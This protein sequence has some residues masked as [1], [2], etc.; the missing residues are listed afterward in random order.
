M[1]SIST[2]ATMRT[3]DQLYIDGSWTST[4]GGSIDVV[5]PSTESVCGRIPEATPAD[6]ELAVRAAATALP[7]WSSTPPEERRKA[8]LAL[9]EGLSARQA[10]LGELISTEQGMPLKLATIIQAGLPAA[11]MAV[12]ADLLDGVV[13]E[14]RIGN[15]LVVKEPVGVVAAITPWNYPLHQI[16]AKVAPALVAGC[17]VV[18]KPSEVAPLNAFVLAE[19][20]DDVGL[21]AGVFNLVSGTGP[22]VGEALVGHELVDMVSFT[23]STRAGRRVGEV[24]A[25]R[26]KKVALELG[27]KS[28]NVLLDDA[29]LDRVVEPG[30]VNACFLNSGQTCTALTRMLVPRHLQSQVVD[31]ARKAAE[32]IVVGPSDAL[33]TRLGPVVSAAQRDRVRSF[34]Q[35]GID[36]GATLV[37]GGVDAPDGLDVGYFIRPTVFADV[38]PDMRIAQEEIFGPVLSIMPYDSDE[39]A[40][41][42]A[43]GTDYGLSG[44]VQSADQDRAVAFARRMRTGQVDVNG[45]PYNLQA[46]F[47]G[48]KQ[49]GIGRENG[50]YGI[51]E[52]LV[53]KGLT[54]PA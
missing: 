1:C 46:P 25:A 14:E 9:A 6:V 27:G 37:T 47:G 15:T 22:L 12:H 26:V 42:I 39:E 34:I 11:N 28:A 43:N 23:G 40:L 17:T 49:S 5:D 45:G 52:Y 18:L 30:V 51:E 2:V 10:E 16:V 8:V 36:E 3:F 31:L 4:D 53:P 50:R 13:W 19:I 44:G 21:P 48:V 33:D 35:S 32:S 41:E 20:V 24:A 7:A 38:T 29:D 54:L